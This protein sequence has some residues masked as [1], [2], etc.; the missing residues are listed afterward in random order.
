[1]F[2]TDGSRFNINGTIL[3]C[4]TAKLRR[5]HGS[6]SIAR[7][8]KRALRNAHCALRTCGAHVATCSSLTVQAPRLL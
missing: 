3:T 5:A 1:M 6:S 8:R 4:A 7:A 2:I